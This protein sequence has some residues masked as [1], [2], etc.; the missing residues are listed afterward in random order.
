MVFKKSWEKRRSRGRWSLGGGVD[1][2]LKWES[3]EGLAR[4][5]GEGLLTS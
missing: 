5:S 2:V 3:N 1:E 4:G